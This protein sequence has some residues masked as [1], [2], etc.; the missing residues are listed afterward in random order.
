[1]WNRETFALALAIQN[2]FWGAGQPIAGAFADRYGTA[3][4]LALGALVYG[5]GLVCMAYAESS[6]ALHLTGGVMIGLGMSAASFSLVLAAFG[7]IVTPEKRS[8]AFGIGTA[9]GSMGQFV[10]SPISIELLESFGWQNSLLILGATLSI[11][12]ML[13]PFLRGRR[14]VEANADGTANQTFTQALS[15]AFGHR[16][17]NLLVAGFFVCGFQVAFIGVHL[18]AYLTDVG[19][20]AKWG[21]WAIAMIGLFNV[22]GALASGVISGR[23]SKAHFLVW[24]YLIRA[25]VMAAFLMFPITPTTVMIFSASMGLLWLSTVPPTSGLVVNMFGPQYM[26]TLFGFVFF[27]HQI[28]SFLGVWLGGKLYDTM[29]NYDMVWYM[30]IALSVFAGIVHWPI[31]DKAVVRKAVPQGA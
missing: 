22:I 17:Y 16:S 5:I 30:A 11:I 24:I 28:G 14:V 1:G 25:V 20:D 2:L 7:R 31:S 19:L 4:V 13:A 18:P 6:L 27:S 29:G 9:A 15:E 10:F 8:I 26:A 3:R 21:A 12:V 23:Y